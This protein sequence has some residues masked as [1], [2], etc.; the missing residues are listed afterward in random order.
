MVFNV[1]LTP[2]T[3]PPQPGK[4][5]ASKIKQSMLNGSCQSLGIKLKTVFGP[6]LN[7]LNSSLKAI[8]D[9]KDGKLTIQWISI[10]HSMHK[11]FVALY[12]YSQHNFRPISN[13]SKTL[14]PKRYSPKSQLQEQNKQDKTFPVLYTLA[15]LHS[16]EPQ[17]TQN[18]IMINSA[19]HDYPQRRWTQVWSAMIN[20]NNSN[21]STCHNFWST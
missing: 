12:D 20:Q 15:W 7:N 14:S 10:Q 21:N 19:K 1:N 2:T 11:Q 6:N 3:Q 17:T 4:Y 8:I 5:Q 16:T 13:P 18:D 9:S